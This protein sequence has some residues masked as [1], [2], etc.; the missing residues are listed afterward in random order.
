MNLGSGQVEGVSHRVLCLDPDLPE[1]SH[2]RAGIPRS[3]Q[4][5]QAGNPPPAAGHRRSVL[6]VSVEAVHID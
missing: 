2:R 6:A 1:P 5:I 3:Q 4:P